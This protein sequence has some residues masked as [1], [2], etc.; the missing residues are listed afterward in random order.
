MGL[1][2]ASLSTFQE[3]VRFFEELE[4]RTREIYIQESNIDDK[5]MKELREGGKIIDA[6]EAVK[7]G[8][9]H[10]VSNNIPSSNDL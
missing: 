8:I 10:K 1:E 7:L 6:E 3:R 9:A 2:R 5:T 4:R